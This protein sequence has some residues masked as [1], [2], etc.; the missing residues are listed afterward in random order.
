MQARFSRV[1]ELAA[2]I[3]DEGGTP[4]LQVVRV[5]NTHSLLVEVAY[6]EGDWWLACPGKPAF[7]RASDLDAAARIIWRAMCS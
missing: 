7:A 5:D 4:M 6:R 3:V 1:R 2:V